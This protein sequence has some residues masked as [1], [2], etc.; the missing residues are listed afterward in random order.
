MSLALVDT[1]RIAVVDGKMGPRQLL[2]RVLYPAIS[3]HGKVRPATGSFPLV[4]FTPGYLQCRSAYS[5]LIDSWVEAGFVAAA[6]G[7]PL[8]ACHVPGGPNESDIVI[9]PADRR[10]RASVPVPW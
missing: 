7:F 1:S 9:P 5:H 3:H 4:V 8:K 6:I 10:K 2:T